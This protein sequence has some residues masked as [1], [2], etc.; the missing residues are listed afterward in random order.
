MTIRVCITHEEPHQV[1]RLAVSVQ[2]ADAH[3]DERPF[4]PPTLIEP[5]NSVEFS[6]HHGAVLIVSEECRRPQQSGGAQQ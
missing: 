3:D 5:G 6:L 4:A 1:R 2:H